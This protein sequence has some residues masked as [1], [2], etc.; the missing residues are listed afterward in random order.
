MKIQL[1]EQCIEMISS[2]V[3]KINTR[4]WSVKDEKSGNDC[5]S[6]KTVLDNFLSISTHIRY[7]ISNITATFS[8]CLQRAYDGESPTKTHETLFWDQQ[9]SLAYTLFHVWEHVQMQIRPQIRRSFNEI[10]RS[11]CSFLETIS[12]PTSDCLPPLSI[13]AKT[14]RIADV[15]RVL[16]VSVTKFSRRK[17]VHTLS[18]D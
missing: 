1:L 2:W 7:F 3:L 17:R 11:N 10:K 5:H 18:L 14:Q 4:S 15:Y 8:R 13:W 6:E 16:Y 12:Q 9:H